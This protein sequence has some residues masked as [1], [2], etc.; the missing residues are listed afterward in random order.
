MGAQV[1]PTG[2][3]WREKGMKGIRIF[4]WASAFFLMRLFPGLRP[5]SLMPSFLQALP[6]E[7]CALTCRCGRGTPSEAL[8]PFPPQAACS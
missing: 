3:A 1:V 8:L 5:C 6:G 2:G 4:T 7:Q